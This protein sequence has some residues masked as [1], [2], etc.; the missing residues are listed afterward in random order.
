VFAEDSFS[1]RTLVYNVTSQVWGTVTPLPVPMQE[2]VIKVYNN[3]LFAFGGLVYA[4][5]NTPT[6]VAVDT[7]LRYDPE[8]NSWQNFATMPRRRW[9]HG[10]GVIENLAF[11]VGG[12]DETGTWLAAID[13]CNL[14]NGTCEATE[15]NI[16]TFL[17]AFSLVEINDGEDFAL[18]GGI[19]INN[20]QVTR[21]LL[22]SPVSGDIS[23]SVLAELPYQMMQPSLTLH[24]N[25][26]FLFGGLY[27]TN[28][29]QP[30]S[31]QTAIFSYPIGSS[32]WNLLSQQLLFPKAYAGALVLGTE[33]MGIFGGLTVNGSSTTVESFTF[34]EIPTTAPVYP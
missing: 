12:W 24:E 8:Q 7:V 1:N 10:V 20:E 30:A 4:V 9:S 17:R 31:F 25:T 29:S 3:N 13:V 27:T 22:F 11:I 5:N 33:Q 15:W 6:Y 16:P 18:V 23:N 19:G 32:Q 34:E 26:L 14:D 28:V 2:H 21:V